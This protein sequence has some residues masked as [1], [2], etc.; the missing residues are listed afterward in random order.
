MESK[1]RIWTMVLAVLLLNIV[2]AAE[3]QGVLGNNPRSGTAFTL[4]LEGGN[5]FGAAIAFTP[6]YNL[7]L[8]DITIWLAGF[9]GTDA[10][11]GGPYNIV[12]GIYENSKFSDQPAEQ[13][14][15]LGILT[16]NNGSLAAFTFTNG[17]A[18]TIL[19]ADQ[20]YWLFVYMRGGFVGSAANWVNGSTPA[21]SATYDGS[22]SFADGSFTP[23]SA[24]PAFSITEAPEPSTLALVGLG[25]VIL[26]SARLRK[27]SNYIQKR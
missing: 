1:S 8:L 11:G 25:A 12:G 26:L 13:I 5:T 15:D 18:S 10:F 6:N 27:Y 22:E 20:K 14:M 19:V 23:S 7:S 4:A 24:T 17:S 2:L 16:P 9:T 21:G 3:A